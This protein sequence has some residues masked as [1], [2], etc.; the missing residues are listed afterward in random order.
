MKNVFAFGCFALLTAFLAAEPALEKIRQYR[1]ANEHRIL[2]E[3][4]QFL[5]IPNVVTDTV[6][7]RRTAAFVA[8]MMRKRGI[9][10]RLLEAATP[11]V[12]PVVFGEVRTPGAKRTVVFY[13]HYD[14]QPVNPAQWAAGLRPFEPTFA[15]APLDK[16]GKI[17]AAPQSGQAIDPESR[18]YARGSSDDKAGVMT[19]LE[20]YRALVETQLKPTVNLKFF[21]EGEEEAGSPHLSEIL[22]QHRSRLQSDLWIICDGPVHQS[23]R[24]QVVF[25]VRGDVNLEVTVYA[26]KRPLHS[27]HYG[28]WAPN[29]AMNL[30]RLLASMKDSTGR[31]TIEGFYDDVVPL[32]ESEKQ[33]LAKVPD[34]DATIQ[35]ELG[36]GR[37]EGGGKSLSELIN[38]PSLNV[39]GL[40]SA[41]VGSMASNVIPTTA[42]AALDLRLVLGNDHARQTEKVV[43]HIERQ[44]FYVTRREPTDGE[45]AQY[46]MIAK[47]SGKSGYN[48]QRTRMDLS[49]ARSVVAAVQATVAE[50]V[51]LLPTSG[52][53]LPLYLFEKHLKTP[54]I[55]VPVVNHDNNQHA[56][57]ENVGIRNL[58]EGLETMASVMQMK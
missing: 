7:I 23:G 25:G 40:Q 37:A 6:N 34:T 44:G 47:V 36:F 39:N 33:A 54:T 13:A 1:R 56:E 51:V 5:A 32:S 26:A 27:G 43:K 15:S 53:S 50:P 48:A 46:P 41:N 55:T 9:E 8:E 19:I 11:G 10:A 52:G 45:R 2:A 17:V 24:K 22:D 18:L 31:V 38:A 16:G 49:V 3:Y 58:W 28:N 30:A 20:A 57:N 29:P 14:G 12:P 42:T 4:T 21:F 35:R